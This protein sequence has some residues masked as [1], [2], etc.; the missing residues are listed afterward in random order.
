VTWIVTVTG[1]R[2]ETVTV[3]GLAVAGVGVG[4]AGRLELGSIVLCAII[5]GF[6]F[7]HD[8]S[9][10]RISR[11]DGWASG[12]REGGGPM[13]IAWVSGVRHAGPPR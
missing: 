7:Q 12:L 1:G 4:N 8:P 9:A 10:G 3:W 2:D 11:L 5:G 6:L 13:R